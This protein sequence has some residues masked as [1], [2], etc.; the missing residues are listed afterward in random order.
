VDAAADTEFGDFMAARWPGLVRLS[1]GLT[2]DRQAAED[3]AQTALAR[4]YASWP[5]VRRA[6][7]PDAYVRRILLNANRARFRTR[8]VAEQLTGGPAAARGDRGPARSGRARRPDRVRDRR[9]RALVGSGNRTPQR[10]VLPDRIRGH[11][12]VL[13][14]QRP[15]D[16]PGGPGG[17]LRCAWLPDCGRPGAAQGDPR[18][19]AARRRPAADPA[20]GG[21]LRP[22]LGGGRA[23]AAG[24]GQQGGGLRRQG[25]V[26]VRN[27]VHRTRAG[28]VS[29]ILAMVAARRGRAAPAGDPGRVR[30]GRRAPLVG[31][32]VQRAVGPVLRAVGR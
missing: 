21:G 30:H 29:H 2:G 4:A 13:R 23:A 11:R 7:D 8:R 25:G 16:R 31:D 9:P 20:S 10:A 19:G 14:A 27:P 22:A 6:D 1:Y 26:P 18:R 17:R 3:L 15:P 24:T 32:R 5:R 28:L 12:A